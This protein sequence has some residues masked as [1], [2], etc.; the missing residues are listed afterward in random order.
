MPMKTKLP[1][2][3]YAIAILAV[4]IDQVAKAYVLHGLHLFPGEPYAVLP[5]FNLT[6]TSNTGVSY[7]LLRNGPDATRWLLSAFSAIVAVVL[8][9]YVRRVE[10]PLTALGVGL[11]IGG[12]VG[13]LIDR[14]RLGA[15]V[16]F[17]DFSALHF[18]WIFNPAD[19]AITIGVIVFL[20]ELVLTPDKKPAGPNRDDHA[21]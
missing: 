20:I 13:N 2:I 5:F 6:L 18:P 7:G 4:I 3:A 17:M 12:A 11:I 21:L 16:D 15:V 10:K 19:S 9:V 1:L 14:V 8:V